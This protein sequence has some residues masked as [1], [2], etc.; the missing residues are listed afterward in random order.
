MGTGGGEANIGAGGGDKGGGNDGGGDDDTG[1]VGISGDGD[2]GGAGG[3]EDSGRGAGDEAILYISQE[4]KTKNHNTP[5]TSNP[6]YLPIDG[7]LQSR[8]T[9]PTNRKSCF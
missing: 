3:D 1:G 7:Y 4:K 2:V 5:T 8:R 6:L 9:I